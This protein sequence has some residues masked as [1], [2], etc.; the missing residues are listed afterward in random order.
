MKHLQVKFNDG[1]IKTFKHE[2]KEVNKNSIEL[3]DTL[4][5]SSGS[6]YQSKCI[7]SIHNILYARVL[8]K[9]K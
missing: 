6:N 2:Y 7:I 1:S 4:P 3:Y 8:E 5:G 9:T